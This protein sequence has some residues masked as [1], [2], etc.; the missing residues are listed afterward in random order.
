MKFLFFLYLLMSPYLLHTLSV[1][2]RLGEGQVGDYIVTEQGHLYTLLA[3]RHL[4]AK[5]LILEEICIPD[6]L[7]DLKKTDWKGWVETKAAKHT[8]WCAYKIDL[9]TH[10][11]KDS[12]SYSQRAFLATE[13]PSNFLTGLLSLSLK[14][15]AE[16]SRRRIG[17]KSD[18]LDHRAL[19]LPPV[20]CEGKAIKKPVLK[21]WE[22]QWPKDQSL[23]AGCR[24]ELYYGDFPF[25]YW[26]EV[27][28]PHYKASIQTIDSGHGLVSPM[29]SIPYP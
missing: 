1:K 6:H 25:P 14:P 18:G 19:W 26:I 22:G 16:N 28:S 4:D 21:V 24:F 7:I 2:E 5:Y 11:I 23:F 17:P 12:Y 13:D 20:Y 8:S 15:V 3:I 9:V 29:P 27:Q 10:Q